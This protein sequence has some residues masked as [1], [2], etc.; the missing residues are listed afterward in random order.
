MRDWIRWKGEVFEGSIEL[1]QIQRARSYRAIDML[2]F[3]LRML[4]HATMPTASAHV[5]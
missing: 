4:F 1:L 5:R 3:N 2:E